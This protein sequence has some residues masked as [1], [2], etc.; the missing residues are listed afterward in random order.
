M[1]TLAALRSVLGRSTLA[2]RVWRNDPDV[3]LLR[4]ENIKLTAEERQLVLRLNT[5]LGELLFTSD[6]PSTY[7]AFQAKE[8]QW[9][10]SHWQEGLWQV[11]PQ[12]N[13]CFLLSDG[14]NN[15]KVELGERTGFMREEK[16]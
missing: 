12:E 10:D 15:W 13:D 11:T 4:D 3:Y 2:G 6:N 7:G 1:S 16:R 14:T 9:Q 8:E 5:H